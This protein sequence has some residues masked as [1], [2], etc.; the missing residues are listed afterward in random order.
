M[1]E[2]GACPSH[3]GPL[4]R[5]LE[6]LSED[7]SGLTYPHG[8]RHAGKHK[9]QKQGWPC[10]PPTPQPGQNAGAGQVLGCPGT[11][12]TLAIYVLLAVLT[13]DT[14]AGGQQPRAYHTAGGDAGYQRSPALLR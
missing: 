11:S 4:G 6:T 9:P 7:T 1:N 3:S 14:A 12:R 8:D 10:N 2:T 13:A 5:S